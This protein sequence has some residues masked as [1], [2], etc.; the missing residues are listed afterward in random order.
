MVGFQG[1][2]DDISE[3]QSTCEKLDQ[4]LLLVKDM[5]IP[6]SSKT[7]V[8]TEIS[9]VVLQFD[10]IKKRATEG[11]EFIMEIEPFAKDLQE[12]LN[13]VERVSSRIDDV[14]HDK[15][16]IDVNLEVLES[17]LTKI[18]VGYFHL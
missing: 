1:M 2:I 12:S 16:N 10:R 5:K 9:S 8:K 11:L 18:E 15:P 13:E 14:L 7:E 3:H 17:E 6:E 4:T